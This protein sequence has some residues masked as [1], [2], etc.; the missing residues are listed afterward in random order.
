M[1]H[2]RHQQIGDIVGQIERSEKAKRHARYV[3]TRTRAAIVANLFDNTLPFAETSL[4]PAENAWPASLAAPLLQRFC[5]SD[6]KTNHARAVAQVL[7]A[8]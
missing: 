7:C 1:L 8:A 6:G 5:R 3:A 4:T 2:Q